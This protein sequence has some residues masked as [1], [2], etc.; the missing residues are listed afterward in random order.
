M[1]DKINKNRKK[2]GIKL[3]KKIILQEKLR[4]LLEEIS[5]VF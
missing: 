4:I 1:S 2:H 5:I 3:K